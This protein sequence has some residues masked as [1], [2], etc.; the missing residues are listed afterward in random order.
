M[1]V[2]VLDDEMK[3]NL[4]DRLVEAGVPISSLPPL[5]GL[6]TEKLYYR[7]KGAKREADQKVFLRK[8]SIRR[9]EAAV[10]LLEKGYPLDVVAYATGISGSQILSWMSEMEAEEWN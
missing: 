1:K 7:L 2:I 5:V 8:K 6:S 3:L 4:A 10:S 9:L